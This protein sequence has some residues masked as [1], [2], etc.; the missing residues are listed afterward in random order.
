MLL[1]LEKSSSGT[2]PSFRPVRP[3]PTSRSSSALEK[4]D[5]DKLVEQSMQVASQLRQQ[6]DDMKTSNDNEVKNL[7]KQFENSRTE[8]GKEKQ[9][10]Q[11]KVKEV[12]YT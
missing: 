4:D 8:W 11:R 1:K 6:V 7:R 2:A 12:Q 3:I 9:E 5:K 10:M